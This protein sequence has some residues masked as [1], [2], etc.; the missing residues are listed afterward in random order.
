MMKLNCWSGSARAALPAD[1]PIGG[2]RHMDERLAGVAN[3]DLVCTDERANAA[4]TQALES[5]K[6]ET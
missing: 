6:R 1:S 3:L 4:I 2:T 5:E